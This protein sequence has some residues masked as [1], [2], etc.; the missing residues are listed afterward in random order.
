MDNQ[1][2]FNDCS[3]FIGSGWVDHL[4]NPDDQED[5]GRVENPGQVGHVRPPLAV[6]PRVFARGN[7]PIPSAVRR[8][9][10]DLLRW[11]Q[12]V[13]KEGRHVVQ[14]LEDLRIVKFHFFQAF[15]AFTNLWMTNDCHT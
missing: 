10:A 6:Q 3:N 15:Q 2:T 4:T 1:S 9:S 7:V 14:Q 12:L 13:P 5:N 11:D 8:L